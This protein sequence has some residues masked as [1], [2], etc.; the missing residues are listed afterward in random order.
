MITYMQASIYKPTKTAM[1]SGT[2]NSTHWILEFVHDG[3]REIES[4][5]GWVSSSDTMQEV[6]VKDSS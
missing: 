5:M 6:T 2:Y 1:Q 3:S 4:V